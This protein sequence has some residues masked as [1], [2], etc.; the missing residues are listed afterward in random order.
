MRNSPTPSLPATTENINEIFGLI[1]DNMANSSF[2]VAHY[3]PEFD[4]KSGPK[5][6]PSCVRRGLF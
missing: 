2:P 1:E 3:V 4:Y 6:L 5:A